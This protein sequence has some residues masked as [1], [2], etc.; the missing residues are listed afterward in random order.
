MTNIRKQSESRIQ[1]TC[2]VTT[3]HTVFTHFSGFQWVCVVGETRALVHLG[4][5]EVPRFT[6]PLESAVCRGHCERAEVTATVSRTE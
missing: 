2:D 1:C 4:S 6:E 5:L 3:V